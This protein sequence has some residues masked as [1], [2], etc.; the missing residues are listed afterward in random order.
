[1]SRRILVSRSDVSW[2][3]DANTTSGLGAL[4]RSPPAR[5][6]KTTQS[7]R[8]DALAMFRAARSAPPELRY[9]M[10]RTTRGRVAAAD[11]LT[12]GSAIRRRTPSLGY[13]DVA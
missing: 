7:N 3:G 2:P 10:I 6:A 9:P 8:V 12:L 5:S 4:S 1:M 11:G 13:G